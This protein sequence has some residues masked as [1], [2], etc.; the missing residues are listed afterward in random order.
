[1]REEPAKPDEE[2]SGFMSES[3]SHGTPRRFGRRALTAIAV[4]GIAATGAA[5]SG[6]GDD[7]EEEAEQAIEEAAEEVEEQGEEIGEEAEEQF[8]EGTEE[9]QEGGEGQGGGSGGGY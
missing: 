7:E 1:M 5:W 6:C 3:E 8:E 4:L 2:G 9:P